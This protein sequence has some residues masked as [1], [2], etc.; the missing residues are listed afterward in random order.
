M[1]QSLSQMGICESAQQKRKI[2][3]ALREP[4][5]SDA[6]V[7][8]TGSDADLLER[9][10]CVR[11]LPTDTAQR[12]VQ[13]RPFASRMDLVTRMNAG[14]AEKRMR[15]GPA[16]IAR[17]FVE[18][19]DFA[20]SASPLS[21]L[22]LLS[23]LCVLI[24]CPLFMYLADDADSR[25]AVQPKRPGRPLLQETEAE[26]AAKLAAQKE[27]R[28]E[29]NQTRDELNRE[30]LAEKVRMLNHKPALND[31]VIHRDPHPEKGPCGMIL[32]Q[33]QRILGRAEPPEIDFQHFPGEPFTI[34][35]RHPYIPGQWEYRSGVTRA[36]AEYTVRGVTRKEMD[37]CA[38]ELYALRTENGFACG[39]RR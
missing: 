37:A 23:Y 36:K 10:K 3:A 18:G 31:I 5:L 30:A 24:S 9:L 25:A 35:T 38:L 8:N 4:P 33:V 16:A 6:V 32:R 12:I 7:V 28:R 11:N 20:T 26:K 19:V 29:W 39:G 2:A 34:P 27:A 13:L 1:T 14:V 17:L 15:I 21:K 22:R